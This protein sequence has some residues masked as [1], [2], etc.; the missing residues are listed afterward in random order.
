MIRVAIER[1]RI[2]RTK[3]PVRNFILRSYALVSEKRP[4]VVVKGD[5][6]CMLVEQLLVC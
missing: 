3:R 1:L 5:Q 4:T 6:P 2:S